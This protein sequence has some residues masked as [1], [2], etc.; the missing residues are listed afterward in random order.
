MRIREAFDPFPPY[1]SGE[2]FAVGETVI[3]RGSGDDEVVGGATSRTCRACWP[4]I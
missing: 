1:P 4:A 2:R 3:E